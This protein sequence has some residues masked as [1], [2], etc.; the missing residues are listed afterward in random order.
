MTEESKEFLVKVFEFFGRRRRFF[1]GVIE[2]ASEERV[3]WGR[4]ARV[5][6]L[7][8]FE[9]DLSEFFKES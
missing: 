5:S 3:L 2:V 8:D 1:C 6:F 9:V 7:E 4:I